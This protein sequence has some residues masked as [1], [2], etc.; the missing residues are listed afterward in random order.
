MA[1]ITLHGKLTVSHIVSHNI[2]YLICGKSFTTLGLA[3]LFPCFGK[4]ELLRFVTFTSGCAPW[5]GYEM[6]TEPN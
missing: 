2:L 3:T 6:A 5:A 1:Y 4:S